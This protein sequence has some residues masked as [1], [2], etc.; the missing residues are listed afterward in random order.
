MCGG[1]LVEILEDRQGQQDSK[2]ARGA[3]TKTDV[4][5]R[6]AKT[7]GVKSKVNSGARTSTPVKKGSVSGKSSKTDAT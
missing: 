6:G 1:H 3:T 5:G 7:G 4:A 2:W